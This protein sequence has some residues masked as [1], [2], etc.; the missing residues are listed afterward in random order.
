[1]IKQKLNTFTDDQIA[2]MRECQRGD[3]NYAAMDANDVVFI[4]ETAPRIDKD[5]YWEANNRNYQESHLAF[6]SDVLCLNKKAYIRF[7]DYAPLEG[8]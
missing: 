4:Y 3:W 8:K 6:L 1:M 5:G 2:S 7:A